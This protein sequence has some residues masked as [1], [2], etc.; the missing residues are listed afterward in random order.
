MR[1]NQFNLNIIFLL[2]IV[3]VA[4]RFLVS[5]LIPVNWDAPIFI[6][7]SYR[8][9]LG[10]IPNRDFSTP[11][12][13][14][15]FLSGGLG[16]WISTP[17][18]LGMNLG[19]VWLNFLIALVFIYLL[20]PEIKRK[21]EFTDVIFFL[22]LFLLLFSPKILGSKPYNLA[23]TGIYN[24]ISYAILMGVVYFLFLSNACQDWKRNLFLGFMVGILVFI[25]FVFFL[26]SFLICTFYL[27][28]YRRKQIINFG[29]GIL[30]A[31]LVMAFT[32]DGLMFFY[33][34]QMIVSY[35]RLQENPYFSLERLWNFIKHT[36]IDILIFIVMLSI[37]LKMCKKF[38]YIGI[39]LF[40]A[41]Y[42]LSMAIMQ[43]P[44][45]ITSIIFALVLMKND[46]I[47]Y[48]NFVFL[49]KIKSHACYIILI[50]KFFAGSALWIPYLL[51]NFS[52]PTFDPNSSKLILKDSIS[53]HI[54]QWDFSKYVADCNN[55]CN[56]IVVVGQNNIYNFYLGLKP[57]KGQLLYWQKGVTFTGNLLDSGSFY[58]K[59][60]LLNGVSRIILAKGFHIDS[61]NEFHNAF[62]EN[63]D[64]NFFLIIENDEVSVYQRKN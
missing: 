45:H 51:F 19:L 8:V 2:L 37:S 61:S 20:W 29:G 31:F 55:D 3:F 53:K 39:L 50:A 46:Q 54:H 42:F 59:E 52:P 18:I 1:E 14:L 40:F 13:P 44:T 49:N 17:S 60:K 63:L 7:G 28:C 48:K 25:K 64:K 11:I 5:D 58:E 47:N 27:L 9:Y 23:Y 36:Y 56:E 12:G 16:M 10:Q 26:A 6:D 15:I 30:I 33:K 35:L 34:D 62:K 38:F 43:K 32:Q 22:I 4:F 24:N 41:E 57:S 21:V